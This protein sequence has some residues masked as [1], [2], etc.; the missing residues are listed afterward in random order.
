MKYIYIYFILLRNE[1]E[2]SS[3]IKVKAV[4]EIEERA[5][6]YKYDTIPIILI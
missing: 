3:V 5:T 6:V 2:S 1:T 4:P